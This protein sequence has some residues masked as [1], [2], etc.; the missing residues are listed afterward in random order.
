MKK[1]KKILA[2]LMAITLLNPIF[3]NMISSVKAATSYAY[4][5]LGSVNRF[6]DDNEMHDWGRE[7][8]YFMA[9]NGIIKG[10]GDNRFNT[11]GSAIFE[12]SLAIVLRSVNVFAK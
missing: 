12:Q 6:A 4:T 10:V 9:N 3:P 5:D 11:L 2:F 1:G 8:I 7:A